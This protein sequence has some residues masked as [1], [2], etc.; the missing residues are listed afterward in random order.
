MNNVVA[1][2]L[3]VDVG[4]SSRTAPW[5]KSSLPVVVQVLEPCMSHGL[6]VCFKKLQILFRLLLSCYHVSQ[7]FPPACDC[8]THFT[9]THDLFPNDRLNTTKKVHAPEDRR[10]YTV[11]TH[12]GK[13]GM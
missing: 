1:L 9:L 5:I 12:R 4:R 6:V 13:L 7:F 11:N 3:S 2:F 10:I 8:C